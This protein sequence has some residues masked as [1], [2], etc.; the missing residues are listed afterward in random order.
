MASMYTYDDLLSAL[1]GA[2]IREG[3]D[4]FIH[5]NIGFLGRLNGVSS[6]QELCD[7][8]IQA[9]QEVLGSKGTLVL[10]TFTYSFCHGE[11]FDP[12]MACCQK[13][14]GQGRGRC[15]PATPIFLWLPKARTQLFILEPGAMKPSETEAFGK[16]CC[17]K[18]AGLPALT[19][20]VD[21]HLYTMLSI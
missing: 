1:R 18:M 13:G 15:V 17:Q 7:R 20:T 9:L 19:L 3:D 6:S 12:N 16:S 11:I 4:V 10:P 14:C 2:G 8:F 21:L 5:S